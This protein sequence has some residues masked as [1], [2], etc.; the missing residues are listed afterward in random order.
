MRRSAILIPAAGASSRMAPRDKLMEAVGGVPLLRDR[1]LAALA[2]E[3][4]VVVTVPPDRPER[5]RAIEDLP[6][7]IVVVPDAAEGM[8]T[9]IAAGA[10][11]LRDVPGVLILPADMPAI[12]TADLAALL[13][14]FE[15]EPT[16][17]HRGASRS[18][19][20]HPVVFPQDLIEPLTRLRGDEGARAIL[21]G[22]A[23][24]V[25]LHPLPDDAALIDLDTPEAWEE[26]RAQSSV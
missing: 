3:A 17:I 14:A 15:A 23:G 24:R 26:W 1:A 25:R 10:S 12:R 6:L 11:A 18:R 2:T 4:P 21:R 16:A 13:D 7:R 19:P 20:G 9:S 22:N 5:R 8:G